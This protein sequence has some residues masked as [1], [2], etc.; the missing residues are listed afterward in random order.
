MPS[1]ARLLARLQADGKYMK[2]EQQ[3]PRQHDHRNQRGGYGQHLSQ[4]NSGAAGLKLLG[5]QSQN[6][7]AGKSEYGAPEE[8]VHFAAE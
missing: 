3:L 7:Q 8:A 4:R 1:P 6:I 2:E 5:H